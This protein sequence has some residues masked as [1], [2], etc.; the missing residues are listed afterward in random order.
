MY[1]A[2]LRYIQHSIS[3]LDTVIVVILKLQMICTDECNDNDFNIVLGN[4]NSTGSYVFL[5]IE[6]RCGYNHNLR[7]QFS[8]VMIYCKIK[9][10]NLYI[11]L[12]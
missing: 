4:K 9:P 8:Y 1:Q 5:P 12:N 6:E 3:L 7:D 10:S 2:M 11:M